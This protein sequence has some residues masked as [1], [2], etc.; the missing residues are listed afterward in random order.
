VVKNSPGNA[1][2][3]GS[4]PGSGRFPGKGNGNSFFLPGKSHGQ[5]NLTGYCPQ[6]CK[7]VG[8]DGMTK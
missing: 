4:V 7:R 2:D 8:Q 6:G 5:R 3:M 1:G